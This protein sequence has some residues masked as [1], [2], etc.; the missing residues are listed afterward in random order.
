MPGIKVHSTVP[1]SSSPPLMYSPSRRSPSYANRTSFSRVLH[2]YA[3]RL[4]EPYSGERHF[5][6]GR[7]VDQRHL[8]RSIMQVS[9]QLIGIRVAAWSQEGSIR[10]DLN[11]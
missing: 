6:I 11:Q 4:K 2:S 7:P 3:R 8:T 1:S 5:A 10:S 9:R